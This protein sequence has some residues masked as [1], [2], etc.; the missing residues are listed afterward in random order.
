[1]QSRS[2]NIK[3]KLLDIFVRS[4]GNNWKNAAVTVFKI[5]CSSASFT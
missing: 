1:M 2:Q 4:E 3:K 5:E